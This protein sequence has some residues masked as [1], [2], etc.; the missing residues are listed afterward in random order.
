MCAFFYPY[1]DYQPNAYEGLST[2][3]TA[4]TQSHHTQGMVHRNSDDASDHAISNRLHGRS[5]KQCKIMCEYDGDVWC[6]SGTPDYRHV[7]PARVFGPFL[8]KRIRLYL[9]DMK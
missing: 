6:M 4:L 2:L 9:N 5:K 7:T 8:W 3:Q 1:P